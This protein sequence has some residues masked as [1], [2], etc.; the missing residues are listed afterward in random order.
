MEKKSIDTCFHIHIQP[1]PTCSHVLRVETNAYPT[2]KQA[3]SNVA[4]RKS[5]LAFNCSLVAG[6]KP[7]HPHKEKKPSSTFVALAS[8][9]H[10]FVGGCA[11]AAAERHLF[12]VDDFVVG[13]FVDFA[14]AVGADG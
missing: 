13:A 1:A 11:V 3:Q 4:I 2:P 14:S 7:P 5:Q 9:L 8:C 10:F 12:A 6:H